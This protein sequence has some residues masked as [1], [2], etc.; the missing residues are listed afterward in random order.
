MYAMQ[1]AMQQAL[2]KLAAASSAARAPLV[3]P[4]E[5]AREAGAVLLQFLR[6][7]APKKTGAFADALTV[8]TEEASGTRVAVRGGGPEPLWTYITKGTAPHEIR[9]VHA[10]AL[11]WDDVFATLVHHPGTKPN[12]FAQEA[13][14]KAQ[15]A[16]REE[17]V[18]SVTAHILA[19]IAAA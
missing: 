2:A 11:H 10:R 17:T 14:A 9:P 19:V 3:P 15:E 4:E 1:V 7:G 8:T 18:G 12:P 6:A 5:R 16:L 13:L